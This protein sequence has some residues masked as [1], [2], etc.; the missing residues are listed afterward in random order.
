[1]G[2]LNRAATFE[3]RSMLPSAVGPFVD[4]NPLLTH[5]HVRPYIIAI[6]L[7]RGAVSFPEI[8]TALSPHC[9]QID[10]KVGAYGE[11]DDCDPDKSRLELITEEVLGEMVSEQIL[12][13]NEE[14][15]IWVLSL[16][17]NQKHLTTII[18]WTS[19]LGGQ[20]PHH[21]FIS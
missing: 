8:L 13:Y 10:L 1:M 11:F 7:H 19:T 17:D 21:L 15:D 18:S 16:G 4:E 9:A 20:V 2:R 3:N 12:R 14:K 6:L 5:A